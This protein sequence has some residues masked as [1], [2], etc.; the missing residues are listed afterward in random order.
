M[1]TRLIKVWGILLMILG[2]IIM[3]TE[4]FRAIFTNH[5]F[6]WGSIWNGLAVTVLGLAF[7]EKGTVIAVLERFA[8][9]AP[10]LVELAKS[11]KPGGNRSYDPPSEREKPANAKDEGLG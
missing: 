8:K 6:R 11:I 5:P 4:A 1:G 10:G 3:G 7:H 9:S 2:T